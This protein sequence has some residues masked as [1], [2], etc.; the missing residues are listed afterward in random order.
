MDSEGALFRN[1]IMLDRLAQRYG[2]L[3]SEVL[4]RADTLDI[5]VLNVSAKWE[6]HQS[7]H[8]QSGKVPPLVPQQKL[9]EMLQAVRAAKQA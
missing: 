1:V 7:E 9:E 5:Y 3:P 6:N 8:S 4:Q 2:C